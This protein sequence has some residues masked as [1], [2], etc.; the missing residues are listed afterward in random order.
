MT[1]T[2]RKVINFLATSGGLFDGLFTDRR[3]S[4]SEA[5]VALDSMA[6]LSE[7]KP[8]LVPNA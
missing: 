5:T 6:S 2:F 8:V 4:L 3:Y 1:I 7:I